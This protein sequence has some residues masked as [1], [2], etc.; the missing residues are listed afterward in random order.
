MSTL[1]NTW[2]FIMRIYNFWI[3]LCRRHHPA[4]PCSFLKS[5]WNYSTRTQE[6]TRHS[7]TLPYTSKPADV[8]GEIGV[9]L[10]NHCQRIMCL[11]LCVCVHMHNKSE[12]KTQD[13]DTRRSMLQRPSKIPTGFIGVSIKKDVK[14]YEKWTIQQ[15]SAHSMMQ[16][17][18]T[19]ALF[20]TIQTKCSFHQTLPTASDSSFLALYFIPLVFYKQQRSR[21]NSE[22]FVLE[23]R[24]RI[25]S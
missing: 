12:R 8:R 5:C 24:H 4:T 7:S 10:W 22:L 9:K 18:R 11:I 25:Q 15:Q 6:I 13:V 16:M 2:M 21:H 19:E 14:Y 3:L 1:S 23:R 20:H 17:S